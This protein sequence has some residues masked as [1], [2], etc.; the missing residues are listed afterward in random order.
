M[1]TLLILFWPLLCFAQHSA[2]MGNWSC[3]LNGF[4][5]ANSRY[6][7]LKHPELLGKGLMTCRSVA[8]FTTEIPVRIALG[9]TRDPQAGNIDDL[10]VTITAKAFAVGRKLDGVYGN[11]EVDGKTMNIIKSNS[12]MTMRSSD[13]M[14]VLPL[15]VSIPKEAVGGWQI[16]TMKISLDE[17]LSTSSATST[18]D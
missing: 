9:I 3:D 10:K 16:D 4:S 12:M 13:R 11:Y 18:S 6:R 15:Q 8:G 14:Q 7:N 5:V 1:K 2:R 17:N